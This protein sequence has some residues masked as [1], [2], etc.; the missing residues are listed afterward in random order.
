MSNLCQLRVINNNDHGH[1]KLICII[2]KIFSNN[3]S[4][5]FLSLLHI[6][7]ELVQ[8]LRT[9]VKFATILNMSINE[10][11]DVHSQSDSDYPQN[12]IIVIL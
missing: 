5:Y 1:A 9:Y 10:A 7:L 8:Y 12:L 4:V 11:S 3:C 2:I 6:Y